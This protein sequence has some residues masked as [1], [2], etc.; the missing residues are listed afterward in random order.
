MLIGLATLISVLFFG[1]VSEYFLVDQLEK[2]VKKYVVEKEQKKEISADLKDATKFIKAFNK[3]RKND[4]KEFKV[5]NADRNTSDVELNIFFDGLMADRLAF[6]DK[7]IRSRI[8]IVSKIKADEWDSI[9][10]LSRESVEKKKEKQQKKTDKG[11]VPQPFAKTMASIDKYITDS[12]RKEKV[13]QAI[14]AFINSQLE[15]AQEFRDRNVVDNKIV[16]KKDASVDELE[17]LAKELNALRRLG[18]DKL[19]DFHMSTK[20]FTTHAEWDQIMK[21]FNKE[22]SVSAH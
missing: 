15:M 2:G 14:Q 7:V 20:K 5:L 19:I 1:G 17:H 6:Q 4:L 16:I 12:E 10:E 11:K 21:T 9:L 22:I 8:A 18:F 13:E 3:E